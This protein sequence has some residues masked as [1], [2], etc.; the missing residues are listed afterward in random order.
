MSFEHKYKELV[1]GILLDGVTRQGRNGITKS[2]FGTQLKIDTLRQ[3]RFPILTGRKMF[4]KGIAGEMAAFLEGPRDVIDFKKY[5]CNYWDEFAGPQ[6]ELKIDY[7]NKWLNFN[8][9]NQ[10]D[11]CIE[12]LTNDPY[13][14]RHIISGWDPSSKDLS[15]PCCHYAYQFY[16]EN[17]TLSMIWIQRSVD[18]MI[19]LPSDIVLAALMLMLMA[20][21]VG[22][23]YGD[24][25]MQMGDTHIYAPHYEAAHEYIMRQQFVPPTFNLAFHSNIK[26]FD[27]DH[28]TLLDYNSQPKIDFELLT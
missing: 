8:G 25:T 13:G 24:I 28:L 7:G 6:G 2:L 20:N 4:I 18:T 3:G 26:N 23:D 14:R 10:I 22:M 15:L 16:V 12:S 27:P 19:G 9:V 21:K 5:G 1:H 17:N 11:A